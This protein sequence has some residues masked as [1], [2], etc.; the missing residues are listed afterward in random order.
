IQSTLRIW[1]DFPAGPSSL[2][3]AT[4]VQHLLT[5]FRSTDILL[6]D[7]V[8]DVYRYPKASLI[9]AADH[10]RST[11]TRAHLDPFHLDLLTLPVI[12]HPNSADARAAV[13]VWCLDDQDKRLPFRELAAGRR[14][15]RSPSGPF[16]PANFNKEGAIASTLI[17]RGILFSCAVTHEEPTFF[18]DLQSFNNLVAK[19][20]SSDDPRISNPLYLCNQMAYGSRI[21][22]RGLDLAEKYFAVESHFRMVFESKVPYLKARAEFLARK[23]KTSQKLVPQ[24]GP[25]IATL[26][27]SDYVYV[28][29]VEMPTVDEMAGL[30]S[31]LKAGAWSGLERLELISGSASPEDVVQAFKL[32]Y[33]YLDSALSEE[34]K[35]DIKFDVIMVEHTLCKVKRWDNN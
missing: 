32:A 24:V 31:G 25:L 5:V 12:A 3:Q 19:C 9:P 1:L 4:F 21:S 33:N 26:L 10:R 6:L 13:Q 22:G 34:V 2:L 20:Q 15:A 14:A 27:A 7:G 35:R 28:D 18:Q 29:K 11:I 17:I 30:V 23:K 8:W 16:H